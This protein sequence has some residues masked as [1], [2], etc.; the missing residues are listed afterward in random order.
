MSTDNRDLLDRLRDD[1]GIEVT[2]SA[3]RNWIGNGGFAR[4]CEG[5]LLEQANRP[6]AVK[7]GEH[8]IHEDDEIVQHELE[9]M[10]ELLNEQLGRMPNIATPLA[11]P[12]LVENHNGER[13]LVTVWE[14]ADGTL[15]NVL[16]REPGGLSRGV[17]HHYLADVASG[18]D[19]LSALGV[20]H[21]DVKPANVL[22][23]GNRA[24]LGD[25]GLTRIGMMATRY[26]A[27][28]RGT[29]DYMPPEAIDG[30]ELAVS[31]TFD[32]Y[33]FGVMYA[34][35]RHGRP[36]FG[37]D[38]ASSSALNVSGLQRLLSVKQDLENADLS[39]L[40]ADE[41]DFVHGLI[42]P[43]REQRNRQPLADQLRRLRESNPPSANHVAVGMEAEAMLSEA[44]EDPTTP[45]IETNADESTPVEG[46]WVPRITPPGNQDEIPPVSI[47]RWMSGGVDLNSPDAWKV[48]KELIARLPE[49]CRTVDGHSGAVISASF[50]PDG[51]RIIS[52][53]HDQTL[54]VCDAETGEC[55]QTLSG[56]E[57]AVISASFSPDGRR[58]VSASNDETVR[59][60]DAETGECLQTLSGHE[61]DVTSASFSTDGRR[62]V[63]ASGDTTVRVWDV[64]TGKCL[65]TLR[66]HEGRV[67]SASFSP[68]GR[69]IVS[70]AD[71]STVRVWDVKTGKC[72]QTLRGH[73]GWVHSAS[74][75]P[76]GRRIVSASDDKT[77]RVWDG[78]TG[79]YLQTLSGQ[80]YSVSSASFSPDGRRIVS[81][82]DDAT[83]RVWDVETGECLQ[84]FSGLGGWVRSARFS[85]DG[86]RIV[87]ASDGQT[88]KVWDA[89][90][91]LDAFPPLAVDSLD[92]ST[93]GDGISNPRPTSAHTVSP[94]PVYAGDLLKLEFEIGNTGKADLEGVVGRIAVHPVSS[95]PVDGTLVFGRVVPRQTSSLELELLL[96]PVRLPSYFEADVRY[97]AARAHT[98][99]DRS[100]SLDILPL[101][102]PDFPVA[103][104]CFDDDS[105]QSVGNGD[106][107]LSPREVVDVEITVTNNTCASIEDLFA[108]LELVRGLTE[109]RISHPQDDFD[110]LGQGET[111]SLRLTVGT[112]L[113]TPLGTAK[114][115]LT[116]GT[117]SGRVLSLIP[118]E[119]DVEAP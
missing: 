59:V 78:E 71:D 28:V 91:S 82:S 77:V 39:G 90:V 102:R 65:Q 20:T 101:P 34:H 8:S 61:N 23:F 96:A 5:K 92:L 44:N 22:L 42:N 87:A 118:F 75:S 64:E 51:R 48:S 113:R 73:E 105:G 56:H 83:V 108:R 88:V 115:L 86:R 35:L 99:A 110:E 72:L 57:C 24:K 98:P 89:V 2:D 70:A 52:A 46:N 111:A 18:L 7:I 15:Q 53:S 109:L 116:V 40:D 16:D 119:L 103:I 107:R 55:L 106:G 38:V 76:D 93:T 63:S 54:K 47:R 1:H 79:K 3:Y 25:F 11:S 19:D 100:I 30:S 17:V 68:D 50:S 66:G 6:V 10:K 97:D 84:S 45:K 36:V 4:V 94:A 33:S 14:L 95:K 114:L 43:D 21:R 67:R 49:I 80:M 58:I 85:P 69:R 31:D 81:A 60:W 29:L 27:G 117:H 26:T 12:L 112:N 13:H 74:F 104:R 32:G 37:N 9:T 41:I 62:V